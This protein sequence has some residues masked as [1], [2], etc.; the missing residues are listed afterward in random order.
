MSEQ[1]GDKS[2]YDRR[3]LNIREVEEPEGEGVKMIYMIYIYIYMYIYMEDADSEGECA[4][5]STCEG[6][7]EGANEKGEEVGMCLGFSL[8]GC[9]TTHEQVV[10]YTHM[11][12]STHVNA[13]WHA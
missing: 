13:S 7:S 10:A 11:R 9:L 2:E 3:S 8:N 5:E 1:G 6:D 4:R 12:C